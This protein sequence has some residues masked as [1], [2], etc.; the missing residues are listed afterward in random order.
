MGQSPNSYWKQMENFV[1]FLKPFT[2]YTTLTGAEGSTTVS[3]AIPI[4]LELSIHL[5]EMEKYMD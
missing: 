1:D 4:I 2:H 5:E 3:T